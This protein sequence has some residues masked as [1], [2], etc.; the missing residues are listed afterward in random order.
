MISLFIFRFFVIFVL[1]GLLLSTGFATVIELGGNY[2]LIESPNYPR[3]YPTNHNK[4]WHISAPEGYQVVIYF[5]VFDLEDSYDLDLGG[6][7][8]YDYVKVQKQILYF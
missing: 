2:G 5:T 6:S 4:T 8:V 7:C 1:E 3:H